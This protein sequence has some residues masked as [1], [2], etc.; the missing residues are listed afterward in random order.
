[1]ISVGS[2]AI[3][4]PVDDAVREVVSGVYAPFGAGMWMCDIFDAIRDLHRS[5]AITSIR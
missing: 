1:M 3:M 2:T 4:S 5:T